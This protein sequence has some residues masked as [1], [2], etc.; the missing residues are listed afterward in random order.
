MNLDQSCTTWLYCH[1]FAN[2]PTKKVKSAIGSAYSRIIAE[3]LHLRDIP[4]P[5]DV[6]N[7]AARIGDLAIIKYFHIIE[8]ARNETRRLFK[9]EFR[10]T[11]NSW[12]ETTIQYA[13][14]NGCPWDENVTRIAVEHRHIQCIKYAYEHDCPV[15][16]NV[17][18]F[19]T[20]EKFLVQSRP[21]RQCVIQ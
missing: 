12:T 21:G 18:S 4:I 16:E 19:V 6:Y 10:V 1:I 15:D 5:T 20:E 17:A 9:R 3:C 8:L 2:F 7:I 13:H 14:E 11:W